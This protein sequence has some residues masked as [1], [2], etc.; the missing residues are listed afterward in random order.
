[1]KKRF[2]RLIA[3]I[4]LC[5]ATVAI[6]LNVMVNKAPETFQPLYKVEIS[7]IEHELSDG[8]EVS[9]ADYDNIIS[10]TADDGS[11]SLYDSQNEY[12][13]RS[14]NGRLY[15]IEY[16]DAHSDRNK[17][18][19]VI[20]NIS[21]LLLFLIIM[22][23]LLYIR[24]SV[25]KPFS[26]V[27][28][29]PARLAKGVLAEPLKDNKNNY[30]RK[31]TW[32]LDMLRE[33]LES[34]H[35][36]ELE[37]AKQEKLLLLSLSHDIKTPLSAIK[38]YSK[39]LEKGLYTDREK[40]RQTAGSISEKADEIEGYVAEII[41]GLKTDVMTF[42][43]NNTEFYMSQVM[44]KIKIYY[45]DKLRE[46]KTQFDI[47]SYNNCM[48][49]GDPDRLEEVIQNIIENAIKYGDGKN[50]SV[51]FSDE[52]DC[53]LITV[54]NS[55]CTLDDSEL[56]HI[57]ESFWRGSNTDNRKGSGL[58]LYICRQLMT[59]MKGDI[60]AEISGGM[61]KVTAVCRKC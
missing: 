4:A 59:G 17:G 33:K 53:R 42:E 39:A 29:M 18:L 24:H 15:R 31:F 14:I 36:R 44:D 9:A 48:L 8:R 58:G 40:Q 10:I 60:F 27:S 19:A 26:H 20:I 21:A 43:I 28:D 51:S 37:R 2:D 55:G 5:L 41:S 6:I 35:A 12:V 11:G 50:I 7:R 61:M 34:S 13:I 16:K 22:G 52:E 47:E 1:M 54:S 3:V 30:F 38:L 45:S 32:G 46:L 23:I 56:P 57:F 25:I 49:S